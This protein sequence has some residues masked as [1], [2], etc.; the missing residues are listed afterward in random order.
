MKR[1]FLS[2]VL[3]AALALGG[4]GNASAGA[5]T[6]GLMITQNGTGYQAWITTYNAFRHQINYGWMHAHAKVGWDSCCYAAG[7]IYYVRAEV[8]KVVNGQMHQIF[9]TTIQVVPKLCRMMTRT[10]RDG[11]P[12][13][14]ARVVLRQGHGETFYWDRDDRSDCTW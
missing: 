12:Y 14:Y 10:G 6:N 4:A 13:G 2:L 7:S 9:D 3:L 11:D 8:K 1:G 5:P